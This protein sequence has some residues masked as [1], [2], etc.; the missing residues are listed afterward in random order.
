VALCAAVLLVATTLGVQVWDLRRVEMGV[1]ADRTFAMWINASA[2]KYGNPTSRVD[3][4]DKL[5]D[6]LTRVSGVEAVGA[7]D[8]TF[9]FSWQ[10][11]TVR[12]G[13]GRESAPITAL[14]RAATSTAASAGVTELGSGR[15]GRF[16]YPERWAATRRRESG[17]VPT[18]GNWKP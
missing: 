3:Y 10:T 18:V 4:F 16:M 11:T 15:G 6:E 12:V 17:K 1:K 8:L 5:S 13:I 9:Q 14:D 7:V 2:G